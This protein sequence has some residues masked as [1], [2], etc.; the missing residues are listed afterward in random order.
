MTS[1]RIWCAICKDKPVEEG[2]EICNVCASHA[3]TGAVVGSRSMTGTATGSRAKSKKKEEKGETSES[4][5]FGYLLALLMFVGWV[6]FVFGF[7]VRGCV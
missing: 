7:L 6:G 4:D 2:R 3:V 5:G 1:D